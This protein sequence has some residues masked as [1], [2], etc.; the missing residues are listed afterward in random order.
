MN[1]FAP[2][3]AQ[4]AWC[5]GRDDVETRRFCGMAMASNNAVGGISIFRDI[6]WDIMGVVMVNNLWLT[7]NYIATDS[8]FFN[9]RIRL[10]V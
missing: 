3:S 9:I 2:A 4:S 5:F 10:G 8:V 1:V 6:Q 7:Y